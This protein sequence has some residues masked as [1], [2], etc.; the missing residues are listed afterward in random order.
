MIKKI[1]ILNIT[2]TAEIAGHEVPAF[3]GAIIRKVGQE[4]LLF[5]NHLAEGQFLYKYPLIQYKKIK[6]QAGIM[7]IEFGVDEIHKYFDK[8]D[9]DIKIGERWIEMKIAGLN[10]NQ[11][12]MQVWDH[13]FYYNLRNWIALNKDNYPKYMQIQNEEDKKTFLENILKGNILSFA[14]GIEWTVEKPIELSI[15]EIKGQKLVSYKG[16]KL[17]GFDIDFRTNV[18]LPNYI[19]LG[20]GVSLGFGIVKALRINS[21]LTN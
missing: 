12:T 15:K 8:K 5:H 16:N 11:F 18:F 9:W 21:E 1:R 14:K 13:F 10:M 7:C 19:G 20:K 17:M 2:F 3:R 6:G 4:N